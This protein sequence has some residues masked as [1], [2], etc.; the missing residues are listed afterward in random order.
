MMTATD[1]PAGQ[2]TLG[3]DALERGDLAAAH[4]HYL[5]AARLLYAL[6]RQASA[7]RVRSQRVQQAEHQVL[8]VE[9]IA[10]PP[11]RFLASLL[12]HGAQVVGHG[13]GRKL[14][15]HAG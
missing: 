8:D 3:L 7:P 11:R 2:L 10:V 6:A 1:R 15:R 9:I 4:R 5:E 14:S 12:D 13:F